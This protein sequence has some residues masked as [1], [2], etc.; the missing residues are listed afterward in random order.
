[1]GQNVSLIHTEVI[2]NGHRCEGWAATAD[3]LSMP[4]ITL[5]NHEIGPDGLKVVSSTGMRGGVVTFKFLANSRSRAQ[6][7]RWA[8]QI[9]RGA[10]IVFQ[11]SIKNK[12]TGESTELGRG[13]MEVAPSGTTLGNAV[14]A[15]REF[16]VHFETVISNFDGV[17]F[18]PAP[19]AV[20]NP[21][22]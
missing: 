6:F 21:P 10:A 20:I 9:Q 17:N 8:A 12:V 7:G 19:P 1:M 16:Q 3:A 14:A 13:H 2:V 5:A 22:A 18:D 4:D 15:A 11:G